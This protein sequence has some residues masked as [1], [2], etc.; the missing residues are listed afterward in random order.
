MNKNTKK[1]Q[2]RTNK[3]NNIQNKRNKITLKVLL[4]A[5]IN[6]RGKVLKWIVLYFKFIIQNIQH[7]IIYLTQ[8]QFILNEEDESIP[9]IL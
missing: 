6:F 9:Y 7:I 3:D 4:K 8:K 1:E 5:F 2:K